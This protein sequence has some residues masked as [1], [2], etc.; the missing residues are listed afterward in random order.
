MQSSALNKNILDILFRFETRVHRSWM[1]SKI[2]VRFRC[3][4]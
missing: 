3:K 4:N 2:D 1:A